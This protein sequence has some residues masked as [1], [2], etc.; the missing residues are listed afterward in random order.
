[1]TPTAD[2]PNAQ[3]P[4]AGLLVI[5]IDRLPA[6]MLSAWGATWVATPGLDALAARGLTVDRLVTTA[7]DPRQTA[8]EMLGGEGGD[9]VLGR[10][11][12]RGRSV[13]VIGDQ[14]EMIEAVSPECATDTTL[15]AAACPDRLAGDESATNVG[16]LFAAA[17]RLVAAGR[18]DVVWVHAGG[19]GIAWD[20]P[21][22]LRQTYLDPD[23]PPPPPDA[24]VPNL[25]ADAATD[26]DSLVS[27]RH[28]FA[29]QLTLLDR[30]IAGLLAVVPRGWAVLVADRKSTR[31]N[32]SHEWISR[33]PSSA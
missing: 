27:L 10:A 1:M 28:V 3:A 12:A 32:S 9:S 20:A 5:T 23:D 24:R 17:S 19:L 31:L 14:A 21:D 22:D 7:A 8:R 25:V 15:V 33:M 13:A 18:H 4:P 26:P 2:S 29:A 11:M 30:S 6:W 16:K